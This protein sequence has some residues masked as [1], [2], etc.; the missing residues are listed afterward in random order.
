MTATATAITNVRVFDGQ[1]LSD[2]RTVFIEDGKISDKTTAATTVDGRGGSLLPGLIDCHIHLDRLQNLEDAA[3]WGITTMLDMATPPALAQ[4]LR[5]RPGLTDIRSVG[6]PASAPGGM[7][8]TKMGFPGQTAISRPE[9]AETFVALRV[10]EGSD[11][12]KI[13]VEDPAVMGSA[14]LTAPTIAALV[15]AAHAHKLLV[16]AHATSTAAFR[17]AADARV[18]V[19]THAP[20]DAPVEP[21]LIR[22]I[23]ADHLISVPTLVM[24]HGV[25]AKTN[26][27]T[28]Q[29]TLTNYQ[30]A[31]LTVATLHAAGVPILVGTD[32]NHAPGS[33]FH[34]KHGE[35]IHEELSLL[36][37]A[38]LTPVEALRGATSLPA[39]LLALED[40][41]T[42][43]PGLRADLLLVDGDP[44][45]DIASTRFIQA[46]WIAGV[47]VKR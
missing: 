19:I 5:R 6:Y 16:F 1:G 32:S 13:I 46:V 23:A 25:A 41:G 27:P 12:V 36:V 39:K 24:M 14:A 26:L 3:D 7:Q 28:H 20:L 11:Y 34:V 22:Q 10:A 21:A 30:N 38:G 42:I 8:T 47:R 17:L 15:Q 45:R 35:S 33:P 9:E 31:V 44:T 4:S 43:A 18:D 29:G 40:R 2:L 37:A